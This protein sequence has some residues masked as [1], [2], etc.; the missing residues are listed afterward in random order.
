MCFNWN[1][2]IAFI[3]VKGSLDYRGAAEGWTANKLDIENV[4]EEIVEKN[5]SINN[6]YVGFSVKEVNMK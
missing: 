1:V 5:Y 6:E 4:D 2:A 3:A